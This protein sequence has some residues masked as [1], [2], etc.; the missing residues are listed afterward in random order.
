LHITDTECLF[1]VLAVIYLAECAC[2]LPRRAVCFSSLLRRHRPFRSPTFMGNED[3]G[4]IITNPLPVASSFV[5]E[6]WPVAIAPDGICLPEPRYRSST[7]NRVAPSRYIA[8]SAVRSVEQEDRQVYV[9]DRWIGK[10]A[11]AEHA[12]LLAAMIEELA[13]VPQADRQPAVEE[14]L[15]RLADV[16]A[17]SVRVS[18][19]RHMSRSLRT[20][21]AIFFL[22]CF[23]YGLLLYY[24]FPSTS[25]SVVGVYLLGFAFCWWFTVVD[26]SALRRWLLQESSGKRWRHM[27]ML[28]LSP[29]SAMRSAESL[30]RNSLAA[31]H[32]LTAAAVL[33]SVGECT[34][35]GQR[36]LLELWHPRPADVP[37][38]PA[39]RRVDEWF[40]TRLAECLEQSLGGI[41]VDAAALALPPAPLEDARSY[42]PR[43]RNQYVMAAGGCPDCGGVPL[44]PYSDRGDNG[45]RPVAESLA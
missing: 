22:Y 44:V 40:R 4:L 27:G 6:C 28:M 36:V 42:C 35:F 25:W 39:A 9:N 43:C 24:V 3:R 23:V 31:Y 12:R 18:V 13:A 26:Y 16:E 32:P 14:R 33:C 30:L 11:S 8:F 10:S 19:L 20:T 5:C 21:A 17:A 38:E 15:R 45:S 41:G 2:W 37:A 34:V 29:G 1:L 7:G